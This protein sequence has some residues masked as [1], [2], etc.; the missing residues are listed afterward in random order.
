MKKTLVYCLE[1]VLTIT[2]TLIGI[3]RLGH[4][5]RPIDTDDVH[6][7]VEVFHSL[8]QNSAEVIVYG[9]SHAFRGLDPMEAYK[10]Y[11]IG[12]Y[13]YGWHWQKMNTTKMFL[14]DSLTSQKPKVALVECF[15]VGSVINNKDMSAEIFY[16]RY[17]KD[18][19]AK[20]EYIRECCGNDLGKYLTYFIPIS[21]FHDNWTELSKGRFKSLPINSTYKYNM[22]YMPMHDAS[23]VD[24]LKYEDLAQKKLKDNAVGCL[25]E[26][27]NT[28]KEND[29]EVVFYIQPTGN[30]WKY[31]DAMEEFAAA[32]DCYFLNL[33]NA[34]QEIG[35][36]GKT[37][38]FDKG[39][40]NSTG[41]RKMADYIGR[42]LVENFDL[43][44]MRTVENNPWEQVLNK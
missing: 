16:S 31:G 13:N 42:F 4:A 6:T 32:H 21:Y 28:C 23:D 36:D 7:Q 9:S 12:M 24:I 14:K 29:I 3:V 30:E 1:V 44:D 5:L 11:G 39:H 40:L 34:V 10:E 20:W 17:I 2:I 33:F 35:L 25:E 27:V 18:R 26:I 8:P 41:A 19:A 37:D 15:Y 43:T 22:G 38:Y